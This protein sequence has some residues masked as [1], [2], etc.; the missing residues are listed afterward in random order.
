MRRYCAVRAAGGVGAGWGSQRGRKSKTATKRRASF[1][2]ALAKE[3]AALPETQRPAMLELID[4]EYMAASLEV[5][6][7]LGPRNKGRLREENYL[8]GML[9]TLGDARLQEITDAVRGVNRSGTM[10]QTDVRVEPLALAWRRQLLDGDAETMRVVCEVALTAG[11]TPGE[12]QDLVRAAAAEAERDDEG[13]EGAEEAL[14][15]AAAEAQEGEVVQV[16][17]AEVL[18]EYA[19]LLAGGG[20]GEA[21]A[22]KA[23]GKRGGKHRRRLLQ[24]LRPLAE[25]YLRDQEGA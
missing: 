25:A 17:G 4:D 8:G 1:C 6:W 15:A 3:L 2:T 20:A 16:G 9:G 7:K 21:G 5:C 11:N 12:V 18:A 13:E 14:V 10:P 22:G 19:E 24:A 23:R